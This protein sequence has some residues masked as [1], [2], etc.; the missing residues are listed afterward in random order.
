MTDEKLADAATI[1]AIR[2]GDRERYR[3]LVERH[4]NQVFA[5]AWCRLGDRS[6]A[7][8]AAQEAFI[9][10]FQRLDLL[11]QTEKFGSWIVAIARNAAINLG[12]HHRNE[13]K[14]RRRWM[15]ERPEA[16]ERP[17]DEPEGSPP[18][19][20][21]RQAL[22][23]LPPIHR[24]CLVLYYLEGKS[25]AEA[26]GILGLSESA[27][28]TRL[29]RARGALRSLLEARLEASMERLRPSNRLPG[30]V[31]FAIAAQKP[32]WPLLGAIGAVVVKVL[33]F[34][35]AFA[36]MQLVGMIPA[37]LL[38]RWLGRAERANFRDPHGFRVANQR[39]F[40]RR[41]LVVVVAVGVV[42]ALVLEP[43]C[44]RHE[45]GAPLESDRVLRAPRTLFRPAACLPG[46]AIPPGPQ[47]LH[48]REHRG[49]F[50]SVRRVCR[51]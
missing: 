7:E 38:H 20:T 45:L 37:L 16:D 36:A 1:A 49:D 25:G 15:L 51:P 6:L 4:A 5:V 43:V 28:K 12:L 11:S 39:R 22:A 48:R 27:F 50:L 31:M 47:S 44:R 29:H 42:C 40:G 17:G 19:E 30:A 18:A 34:S 2:Q 3:E 9:K 41:N 13:L 26:A 35:V 46:T 32:A 21:V 8:D 24:E 33:P 10:G 14:Q 23:E